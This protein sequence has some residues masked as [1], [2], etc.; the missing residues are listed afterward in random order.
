MYK[1]C[2]VDDEVKNYRLFEKLVDWKNRG[3]EIV[4]TAAD[5]VEALQMYE[6]LRPDLI[7][8]DI[9][10]PLMDGLECIRCI[11]EEDKQV[12][13]VIV[14]AYGDFSYAQKAIRY[15]VQDFLLKPVSRLM[16]NQLMDKM[17]KTLDE[18]KSGS[19]KADYYDNEMA[20]GLRRFL[21]DG[22]AENLPEISC[23]CR[24]LF[25][26]YPGGR[27]NREFIDTLLEETKD[28]QSVQAVVQTEDS[29]Y[30]IWSQGGRMHTAVESMQSF[31][32]KS[33]YGA[34]F[35]PW[36][37]EGDSRTA[38]DFL[39]CIFGEENYGFYENEKKNP[40][41]DFRELP[42]TEGEIETGGFDSILLKAMAE[43]NAEPI[44]SFVNEAFAYAERKRLNPKIL[45]NFTLDVLLKIKFCMK[46]FDF[47]GS[48][49]MMRNVR[50]E[51]IYKVYS[52]ETLKDFLTDKITETFDS[53]DVQGYQTG[54]GGSLVL[55]ANALAE[56]SYT[57]QD[58]S[59]QSAADGIGISKNYFISLYKEHTGMGYWEYVT[60]L[61][62]E[63]AK[64]ILLFT[65][66][67]VGETA[68]LVGYDS[69]YYFSRKFKEYT[70]MSP[71][72]FQKS[73]S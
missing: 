36:V 64:E 2:L 9:Q 51:R 7:F 19:K 18:R 17:K 12:Q 25:T 33:R 34:E 29:V 59:V 57:K 30:I 41:Y 56:L 32:T 3:F 39:I 15:G 5:G 60:K 73:N 61:R 46:R 52:Q 1:V 27:P 24:I 38:A 68:S 43:T 31:L 35:Y 48:F 50:T 69:E 49:A 8:M 21:E 40:V 22:I 42:Y 23:L 54:K 26:E 45:K 28:K 72:Q 63:K 58:F 71:K 67:A 14:S 11:R 62:M 16:I 53:L 13:I 70:G 10:L 37:R 65:D 66:A 44:L 6:N 4:G 47:D 20:E 55:K